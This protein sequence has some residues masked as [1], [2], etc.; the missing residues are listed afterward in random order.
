MFHKIKEIRER[1]DGIAADKANFHLTERVE[2]RRVMH[3]GKETHSF[4]HALDVIGRDEDKDH[5]FQLLMHSCENENVSVISIVGIGGLGKTTLAKLVY[6]DERVVGH[7]HMKL[8]V[9][10]SKNFD[11]RTLAIKI[12]DF[13]NATKCGDL[14]MD[15]IQIVLRHALIG[16]TFFTHSE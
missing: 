16:K 3:M 11:V 9:C 10:V 7:F 1:L 4:V 13:A 8:W 15:Q 14:T 12:I 5:I 6:N 2:D